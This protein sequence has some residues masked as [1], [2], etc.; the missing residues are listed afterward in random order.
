MTGAPVPTGCEAVNMQEQTEQ[1]DD[2]ARFTADVRCDKTL[3]A[4]ARILFAVMVVFSGRYAPDYCRI[5]SAGVAGNCRCRLY[6]R[7]AV[8]DWRRAPASGQPLKVQFMTLT[9]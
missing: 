8:L 6:A 7:G 5:A 4:A 1:T 9:V 2:G 3:A